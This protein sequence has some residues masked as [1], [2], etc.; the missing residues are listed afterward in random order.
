M[1][2][3]LILHFVFWFGFVKNLTK[4]DLS[5]IQLILIDFSGK[6]FRV[7]KLK[8]KTSRSMLLN[9]KKIFEINYHTKPF[10]SNQNLT[11]TLVYFTQSLVSLEQSLKRSFHEESLL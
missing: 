10:K 4:L 7:R 3:F 9:T 2:T 1:I 5:K 11:K 6:H 8:S